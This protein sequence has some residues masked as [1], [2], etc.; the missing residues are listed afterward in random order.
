MDGDRRN[1]RRF[2]M[3]YTFMAVIGMVGSALVI[4]AF[5]ANQQ[6]W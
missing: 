2:V 5:F 4:I 3:D 6:G 1:L